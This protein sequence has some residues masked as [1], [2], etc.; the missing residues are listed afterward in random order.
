MGDPAILAPVEAAP[1]ETPSIDPEARALIA[2]VEKRL[3]SLERALKRIA[4][5]Q[6]KNL[7]IF[8]NVIDRVASIIE[9]LHAQEAVLTSVKKMASDS[10]TVTAALSESVRV[11]AESNT[12]AHTKLD[13]ILGYVAHAKA[14]GGFLAKYGGKIAFF[15]GGVLVSH[16]VLDA[17]IFK[18]F[19]AIFGM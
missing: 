3:L 18:G 10:A 13:D 9:T 14:A 8:N 17:E 19:F 2:D 4:R 11:M 7:P 16:G 12:Q 5:V 1:I 6:N 15:V